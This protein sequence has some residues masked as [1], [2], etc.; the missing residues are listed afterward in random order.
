VALVVVAMA[1]A[2]AVL[3][4]SVLLQQRFLVVAAYQ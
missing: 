2:G 1:L 4:D 3:V